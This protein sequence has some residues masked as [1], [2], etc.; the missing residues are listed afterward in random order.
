[1]TYISNTQYT[2]ITIL[3]KALL[4]GSQT[5]TL[6]WDTIK[7]MY[8][9][10]SPADTEPVREQPLSTASGEREGKEESHT[11]WKLVSSTTQEK[12][13][14]IMHVKDQTD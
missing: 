7:Y 4:K 11:T 8:V 13:Q 2:I 6:L 5:A 10:V 3:N 12:Q 1:M 14:F 9:Y